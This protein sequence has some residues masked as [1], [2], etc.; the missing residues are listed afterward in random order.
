MRMKSKSFASINPICL[1]RV[2]CDCFHLKAKKRALDYST[3]DRG[4]VSE[5]VYPRKKVPGALEVSRLPARPSP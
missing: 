1:M 3:I 2:I 5:N 4:E